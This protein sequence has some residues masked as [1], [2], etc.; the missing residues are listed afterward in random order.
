MKTWTKDPEAVLD[1]PVDWSD[2]LATGET[3]SE[4]VWTVPTGLT[5]DSQSES[6]GVAVAWISGGTAG[7]EYR[8]EC[9]VTTSQGRTDE[10]SFF[11][12]VTER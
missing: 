8:I 3:I 2:W 9:K 6:G 1:Y 12:K 5:K 10:R 11:I 7:T 4:V